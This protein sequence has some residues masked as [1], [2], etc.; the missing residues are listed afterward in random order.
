MEDGKKKKKQRDDMIMNAE[1][2]EIKMITVEQIYPITKYQLKDLQDIAEK[3]KL[4][5]ESTKYGVD[6][7]TFR[8]IKKTKKD[9]YDE[10]IEKIK[11]FS[12]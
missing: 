9:L 11:S 2:I 1:Q 7:K 12:N 8:I 5:L 6:N 10:I 4:P 3:L